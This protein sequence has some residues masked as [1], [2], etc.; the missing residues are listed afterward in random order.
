MKVIARPLWPHV[1]YLCVWA[2]CFVPHAEAEL[3]RVVALIGTRPE[4]IKMAPVIWELQRHPD[5]I[6]C[7]VVDTGQ[8]VQ[9][10]R[11]LLRFFRITP[12]VSLSIM[13]RSQSLASLSSQ[14]ATKMDRALRKIEPHIILVQGDTTSAFV[15][16]LTAFYN[17]IPVGHVEAGLRTYN[18]YSPFPEEVRAVCFGG[19]GRAGRRA[20]GRVVAPASGVIWTGARQPCA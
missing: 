14:L 5:T 12:N 9:M 3:L 16:G 19:C 13:T 8:H 10:L 7:Y 2:L 11:P 18:L 17:Q 1:I 4:A 20:G 6:E 15:S